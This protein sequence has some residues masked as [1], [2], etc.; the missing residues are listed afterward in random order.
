MTKQEKIMIG[1]CLC[2]ALIF[3]FVFL[4]WGMMMLLGGAMLSSIGLKSLRYFTVL[5]NLL[6]GLASLLLT[7]DLARVLR[8][9][10]E[11]VSHGLFLLGHVGAVAVSITFWVVMCFLGPR[12][13]YL[14]MFKGGNL[15]LHLIN[16]LL[17]IA[18]FFFLDHFDRVEKKEL[19]FS[20]VPVLIYGIFY[21]GNVMINGVGTY[22]DINDFYGFF[23]AGLPSAAMIYVVLL[24]ASLLIGAVLRLGNGRWFRRRS[25]GV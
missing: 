8:G 17:A 1:A 25:V 2:H 12:L 5:S 16:P 19:W 13:G 21:L 6:E 23:F 18:A 4:S 10:K 14:A 11:R 15:F 22:P 7:I 24:A 20:L 3:V 9:K